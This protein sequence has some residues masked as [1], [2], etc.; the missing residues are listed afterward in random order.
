MWND[1][2]GQLGKAIEDT[3]DDTTE[4]NGSGTVEKRAGPSMSYG[5][6]STITSNDLFSSA[7]SNS[8]EQVDSAREHEQE[9]SKEASIDASLT[10]LAEKYPLSNVGA[11]FSTLLESIADITETEI[12]APRTSEE[13]SE[14]PEAMHVVLPTLPDAQ[15]VHEKPDHTRVESSEAREKSDDD[16]IE[17]PTDG[18]S[19]EQRS[20]QPLEQSREEKALLKFQQQL[21]DEMNENDKLRGEITKLRTELDYNRS[22]LKD[23]LQ[24]N[25]MVKD[26]PVLIDK[27]DREREKT[28]S[29]S[30]DLEEKQDQVDQL[31]YELQE[32]CEEIG[33]LRNTV[34]QLEEASQAAEQRIDELDAVSERK[35]AQLGSLQTKI[36]EL[37][38]ENEN[39]VL[40]IRKLKTEKGT[41]D[42]A[43]FSRLSEENDLLKAENER[44]SGELQST[45]TEYENRLQHLDS[46]VFEANC[47]ANSA[48]SRLEE[49]ERNAVY[50]LQNVRT[51]V[52]SMQTLLSQTSAMKS[53]LEA[54]CEELRKENAALKLHRH[55][56]DKK[57]EDVVLAQKTEIKNLSTK[58]AS[59]VTEVSRLQN[60]VTEMLS[61]LKDKEKEIEEWKQKQWNH[62]SVQQEDRIGGEVSR[63]D[64]EKTVFSQKKMQPPSWAAPAYPVIPPPNVDGD[65]TRLESEVVRQ[66]MIIKELKKERTEFQQVSI[67]FSDLQRKHDVL[68][69]M[70]GEAT[71]RIAFLEGK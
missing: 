4:E 71:E 62:L 11:T 48:E 58:N 5:N 49:I 21:S 51:D 57:L 45:V 10:N 19:A 53:A 2:I 24:E 35:S 16:H 22:L 31:Q 12:L 63:G 39:L 47:R 55:S 29:L 40:E 41:T 30:R 54:K 8:A 68:L 17:H 43:T 38:E 28:K 46:M 13:Q 20:E 61:K 69:Q 6:P 36:N 60:E 52:D 34:Q 18:S 37:R 15:M 14:H 42:Q 1:L 9:V 67:Q 3:F 64:T 32:Y 7:N 65:K 26:V 25:S 59:L 27:L 50:S 66:A 44:L 23:A 33:T 56:V 70:Y